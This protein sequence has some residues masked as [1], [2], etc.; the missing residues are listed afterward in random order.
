MN[1]LANC[2]ECHSD[3]LHLESSRDRYPLRRAGED[4]ATA[5]R[6]IA[7]TLWI[8]CAVCGHTYPVTK[9]I[10]RSADL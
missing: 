5:G 2:P 9:K 1:E 10:E 3:D 6:P 7:R 4:S 8:R